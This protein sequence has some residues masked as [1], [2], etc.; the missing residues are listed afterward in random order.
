V[1]PQGLGIEHAIA[2]VEALGKVDVATIMVS[3][4]MQ[5]A[6]HESGGCREHFVQIAPGQEFDVTDVVDALKE[7]SYRLM[8]VGNDWLIVSPPTAVP[9]AEEV[10]G[11]VGRQ[12][13][14]FAW[15]P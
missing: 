3:G 4:R 12:P 7:L 1:T 13:F 14:Q 6:V 2:L 8:W 10:V 15:S 11:P 9:E 5:N